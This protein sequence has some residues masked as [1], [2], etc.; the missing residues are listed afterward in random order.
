MPQLIN[1]DLMREPYN[2]LIVALMLAIATFGLALIFQ[3]ANGG[4]IAALTGSA[5]FTGD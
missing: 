4:G 5:G 1:W 2:W 3:S